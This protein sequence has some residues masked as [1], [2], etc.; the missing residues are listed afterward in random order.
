MSESIVQL[1]QSGGRVS[2]LKDPEEHAI[3]RRRAKRQRKL[4]GPRD[5]LKGSE[6]YT[7]ATLGVKSAVCR[8]K[9]WKRIRREL[10]EAR[11][12][13]TSRKTIVA[14]ERQLRE[15]PVTE[16]VEVLAKEGIRVK[17]PNVTRALKGLDKTAEAILLAYKQ[18]SSAG[19]WEHKRGIEFE[20]SPKWTSVKTSLRKLGFET[21]GPCPGLK[22]ADP[23]EVPADALLTSQLHH[24]ANG[25]PQL[26]AQLKRTTRNLW[27]TQDLEL[28]P[29]VK[30]AVD[31]LIDGWDYKPAFRDAKL[32]ASVATKLR[33]LLRNSSGIR[34]KLW[35][36]IPVTDPKKDPHT[37]YVHMRII[38]EPILEANTGHLLERSLPPPTWKGRLAFGFY[39]RDGK[40]QPHPEE[41]PMI[42]A[43]YE[44]L[45]DLGD[46]NRVSHATG[47]TRDQLC[48]MFGNTE[49]ALIVGYQKWNQTYDRVEDQI[50][51]RLLR[52]EKC[53]QGPAS[54]PRSRVVLAR[55]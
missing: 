50:K 27:V 45:D 7:F 17:G 9:I 31:H 11:K 42:E 39:W 36:E 21:E 54:R 46:I 26:E 52:R 41:G 20:S 8:T 29:L 10:R 13:R 44:I 1:T 47:F 22:R 12:R 15:N 35:G 53:V 37:R 30:K 51:N 55:C 16:I 5:A 23:S 34:S 28:A 43:A 4:E 24:I 3:L 40:K 2:L 38:G 18:L 25:D 19:Y 33:S 14:L 48:T 32:P 6:S 49:T